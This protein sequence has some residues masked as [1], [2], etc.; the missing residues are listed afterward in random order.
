[1]N[2]SWLVL[3]VFL[4]L[5]PLLGIG[6][7][8]PAGIHGQAFRDW[9]KVNF[10]D[11][12]HQELGYSTAR[13]YMYG[14]LDNE[15]DQLSCV[16]GGFQVPWVAGNTGTNPAPINCEH[17]V[18]QS[19]YGGVEPMKSDIHHLFPSYDSW[20]TT[21]NNY[22]FAEIADHLTTKWMYLDQS[23]TSVPS[24]DIDLYSEVYSQTFEPREDHKGDC[25]RAVFYF[26]TMYPTQAG[27]IGS[28][29]D[30]TTLYL[31]HL[32]D[33]PDAKEMLRND[34]ID[35]YQGNRNPYVDHPDWV[36]DAWEISS[37]GLVPP[38]GFQLIEGS[39]H[40]DLIWNDVLIETGYSLYRSENNID[41]TLLA[42]LP[43]DVSS[44]RDS[45]VSAGILYFYA[46]EA[47]GGSDTSARSNVVSGELQVGA[48]GQALDLFISEY[49]E[50]SSH[51]KALEIANFTGDA[52][53]LDLYS[54]KKQTNGA[55]AWG[56]EYMLGGSL[57]H[58]EV[59]VIA[60]AAAGAT[61]LSHADVQTG[62][63]IVTFNGNDALGLFKNGTL[64]DILGTFDG[65]TNNYAKDQTLV[66]KSSIRGPRG[67]YQPTEWDSYAVNTFSDLGS[68]D[69]AIL[70]T[71]LGDALG[72]LEMAKAWPNPFDG[73]LR[74][75]FELPRAM[76]VQ[77]GLYDGM[78]RL[79]RL[80]LPEGRLLAGE[81]GFLFGL[82]DLGSGMYVIGMR[83]GTGIRWL[84]VVKG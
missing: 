56:S 29:G 63:G 80:L 37:T 2:K 78:G 73:D 55:G 62:G 20:N 16:Y 47:F 41:Y 71:G 82:D 83:S 34:G 8:P 60:N 28:V 5:L 76:D 10:Y 57:A 67:V 69:F 61:I 33:P 77:I 84:R 4:F 36:G 68:H 64:L 51:N 74:I 81:H 79:V 15:N 72:N 45:S 39:D 42:S 38:S 32:Q 75:S 59:F 43:A 53:N 1:M 40:L 26:Y 6:Q 14:Y 9:L 48:D 18:P 11:G 12:Q 35:T 65:G 13:G 27:L 22:A 70:G 58:G 24:S 54:L 31:W 23:Q 49:I 52:V 44:Y 19:F 3:G 7:M 21:R 50:G 25:A 17:T 30:L 46:I 66:R